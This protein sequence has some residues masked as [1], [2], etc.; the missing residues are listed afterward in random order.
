MGRRVCNTC[1]ENYNIYSINKDGYDME[2]L[3]PKT[4]GICDK[5]GGKLIIRSDDNEDVISKR[6]KEYEEKTI[7]LLN[8][9]K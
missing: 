2:P 9:Y 8:V 6:M 4:E 7:P 3:L 5:D 1:G